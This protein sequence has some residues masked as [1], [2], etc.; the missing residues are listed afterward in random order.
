MIYGEVVGCLWSSHQD[1]GFDR[2]PLKLIVPA[3]ARSGETGGN[4][5][6]AVDL[7]GSRTG[8]KVL[9]VYEGSSS[10]LCIGNDKT[11]CEAVVVGI[12]DQADIIAGGSP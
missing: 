8:D 2:L 5:I 12:V 9:V 10:R 7:V 1:P 6:V 4:T 3:D 11:P